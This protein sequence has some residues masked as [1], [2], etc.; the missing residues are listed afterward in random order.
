MKPLLVVAILVHSIC[1]VSCYYESNLTSSSL[2][3]NSI[4]LGIA[5]ALRG[6]PISIQGQAA[7]MAVD[8]INA[9]GGING[10][11]IELIIRD[12]GCSSL[13]APDEVQRMIDEHQIVGLVGP[14]CSSGAK[15]IIPDILPNHNLPTIGTTTTAPELTTL[16]EGNLFFRLRTSDL[17]QINTLVEEIINDGVTRL[18]IIH[19]AGNDVFN[20]AI[21]QGL[22]DQFSAQTG[23]EVS[24]I[25]GYPESSL[26]EFD[27]EV[28]TLLD[29]GDFD[30]IAIIGFPVDSANVA[31]AIAL[32]MANRGIT[33]SSLS[34]V[35]INLI[36][37]INESVL[38]PVYL[39]LLTGSKTIRFNTPSALTA[40]YFANWL[41][42]F[43]I[44]FPN[45]NF[46]LLN[47]ENVGRQHA[48]DGV[49]LMA[50]AMLQGGVNEDTS[51]G[52]TRN[53]ILANLTSVSGSDAALDA[54]EIK[55]GE[56]DLAITTL[57]AG[58]SFNYNGASGVIDFD[59]FG[60]VNYADLQVMEAT[61]VNGQ[62]VYNCLR[63]VRIFPVA[64]GFD[65]EASACLD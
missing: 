30:G 19:R 45:N 39:E 25:V 61:Q 57:A 46:T 5:L 15:I 47:E 50:L 18:A 24:A 34:G 10:A 14:T 8:E 41:T 48:Y 28:N 40:P 3:D 7:T 9:A 17:V 49:Y 35:Y 37:G 51:V 36:R 11:T 55:P 52:D 26:T 32:G 33:R 22:K 13:I 23:K 44:L 43:K 4:K 27:S 62:I 56:F 63:G 20:I 42:E 53:L 59:A 54:V 60:D 58:G 31:A 1:L 64:Q 65:S 21:A 2:D 29:A 6:N 16:D 12:S 38:L